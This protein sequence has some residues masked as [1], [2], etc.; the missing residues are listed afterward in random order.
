MLG[1]CVEPLNPGESLV[2]HDKWL[3]LDL[4][5]DPA[6]DFDQPDCNHA[7]WQRWVDFVDID[8]SGECGW[9]LLEQPLPG[10]L[11]EGDV[12]DWMGWHS[13]LRAGAESEAHF[14]V[15]IEQHLVFEQWA[16]IPS[17]DTTFRGQW[18][19]PERLPA[20]TPVVL[21]LHNHGDNSWALRTLALAPD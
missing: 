20:G 4:S 11:A 3:A 13:P 21:H 16:P 12:V 17:G 8:T 5:Q 10:T 2:D 7:V 15:Y 14:A 18:T 19:V 9:A 6:G 1:A